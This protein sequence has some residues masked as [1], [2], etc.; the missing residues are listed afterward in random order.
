MINNKKIF[1]LSD[2]KKKILFHKNNCKEYYNFINNQKININKINN[3]EDLPFM[4]INMFK[5][6]DLYSCKKKE[7]I[8]QLNSSGTSGTASKIYLDKK[9]SINQKKILKNIL[10]EKFGSKR[11]P[12]LIIDKNPLKEKN[13][14]S[15][16]AKIAAILGFA[17]IGYDNTYLLDEDG[18]IDYK[19]LNQFLKKY[20]N[21]DFLIFGFTYTVYEELFNKLK[22]NNLR[23]SFDN[24][25]LLHGGGW[26]KMHSKSINNDKFKERLKKKLKINKVINYFGFVEQTG[27]VFLECSEFGYFHTN[28]YTDIIVRDFELKLS[29]KNV[30]G[31]LQSLS[32]VPSSYP[33][34][35]LLLE[36]QASFFGDKCKCGLRGKIFK[37]HERL[38]KA[39]IRGCS[40]TL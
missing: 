19:I 39:E 4:H 30:K 32:L 13:K 31:V 40:D 24:A 33:G 3:I 25:I 38:K 22:I 2:I 23:F 11:L 18:N 7:I 35:S 17:L 27:T 16:N 5:K 29:K 15:F 20:S 28:R 14:V 8:N 9:N 1:F 21:K 26:K 34:N 37:I 12:F 10:I 36:D 6:F